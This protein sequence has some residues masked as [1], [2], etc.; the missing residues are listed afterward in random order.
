M[1]YDEALAER[2]RTFLEDTPGLVERK[3]FGGI[4]W[5]I[6]GHMAAGAHSDGKLMIRSSK[7]DFPTF[8]AEHPGV[9]GMKRG[10]TVMTGWILIEPEV[11]HDETAFVHWVGRGRDYAAG[12]PPKPPKAKKKAKK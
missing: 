2:I 3:M 9:N 8:I 12:L 5:M 4:G 7:E 6:G 11:V 1:A 10:D